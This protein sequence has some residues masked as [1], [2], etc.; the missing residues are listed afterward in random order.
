MSNMHRFKNLFPEPTII[1][2][3]RRM[4]EQEEINII[5]K[6]FI[7]FLFGYYKGKT[8]VNVDA[9]FEKLIG[10]DIEKFLT[11]RQKPALNFSNDFTND[12]KGAGYA[13]SQGSTLE[14]LKSR[15]SHFHHV[16]SVFTSYYFRTKVDIPKAIEGILKDF[17]FINTAKISTVNLGE[18][19]KLLREGN[20]E[21]ADE[22]INIEKQKY[23]DNYN[24]VIDMMEYATNLIKEMKGK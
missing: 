6:E 3:K 16:F 21:A 12:L 14:E 18:L 17:I 10:E 15:L 8:S 4:T 7:D 5:K 19:D 13:V 23:I 20:L 9:F 2:E 22:L 1:R 24:S 11:S